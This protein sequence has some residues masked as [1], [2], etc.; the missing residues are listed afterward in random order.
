MI[1]IRNW[2]LGFGIKKSNARI[3]V[4]RIASSITTEALT[5]TGVEVIYREDLT[6]ESTLRYAAT[7]SLRY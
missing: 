2:E 7:C 6:M 1:A 3:N 4:Y 5:V